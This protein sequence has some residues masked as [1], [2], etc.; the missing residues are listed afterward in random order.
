MGPCRREH[1]ADCRARHVNLG[2]TRDSILHGLR[3]YRF[4]IGESV[5]RFRVKKIDETIR[6]GS[7]RRRTWPLGAHEALQ[8]EIRMIPR[9]RRRHLNAPVGDS[10]CGR[11]SAQSRAARD[12]PAWSPTTPSCQSGPWRLIPAIELN[13]PLCAM[14]YSRAPCRRVSLHLMGYGRFRLRSSSSH[15]PTLQP[16]SRNGSRSCR[17]RWATWA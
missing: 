15:T 16:D 10:L 7:G 9:A 13:E 3:S 4:V 8:W 12:R 2:G 5:E 14:C 11:T 17:I 6:E 1:I